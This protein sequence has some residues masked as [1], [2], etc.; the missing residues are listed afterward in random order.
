MA[1]RHHRSGAWVTEM[2]DHPTDEGDDF[3]PED[4]FAEIEALSDLFLSNPTLLHCVLGFLAG[5]LK[6]SGEA[7]EFMHKFVSL[8]GDLKEGYE[9]R[10]YLETAEFLTSIATLMRLE[11]DADHDSRGP[12]K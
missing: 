11:L 10:D 3:D 8:H 9:Q 7:E 1:A 4:L 12:S 2:R 6:S 5:N